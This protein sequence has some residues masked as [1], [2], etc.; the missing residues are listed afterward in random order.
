MHTQARRFRHRIAD[1]PGALIDLRQ[2]TAAREHGGHAGREC[3]ERCDRESFR[4]RQKAERVRG[5]Q[6]LL[7]VTGV[8]QEQMAKMERE[9]ANLR[10][11]PV[12]TLLTR[13]W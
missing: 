6:Q 5:R 13:G 7:L 3:F 2:V 9:M 1:H 12:T 10:K 8:T 11:R 4:A